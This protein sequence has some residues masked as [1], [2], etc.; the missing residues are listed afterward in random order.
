M[1]Q[2]QILNNK[3]SPKK[4]QFLRE[5]GDFQPVNKKV[6]FVTIH[7]IGTILMSYHYK[8]LSSFIKIVHNGK[9]ICNRDFTL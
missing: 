5:S 7:V 1:L 8:T 2:A 9:F 6:I 4:Q 3:T